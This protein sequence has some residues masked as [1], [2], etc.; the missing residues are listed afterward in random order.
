MHQEYCQTALL[1]KYYINLRSLLC[2]K[3]Y[4]CEK[5]GNIIQLIKKLAMVSVTDAPVLKRGCK[6]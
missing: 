6:T 5:L 1:S 2:T 3:M 4:I